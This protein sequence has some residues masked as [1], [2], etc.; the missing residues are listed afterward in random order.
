MGVW[1]AIECWFLQCL[2]L[3]I[4]SSVG[5]LALP[6]VQKLHTLSKNYIG[7]VIIQN[8]HVLKEKQVST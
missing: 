6:T 1:N 7:N 8:L 2:V 4:R 3:G 5:T